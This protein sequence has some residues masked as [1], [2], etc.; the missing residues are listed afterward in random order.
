MTNRVSIII[1]T[2]NCAAYV[3][4]AVRSALEQDLPGSEIIVVDDGSSDRTAELLRSWVESGAIQYVYQENRGLPGARNTGA[5]IA[6]GEYLAFLDADDVFAPGAVRKMRDAM[7][8]SAAGWCLVDF[9]RISGDGST[10][11]PTELP[12]G[13]PFQS[14][15]EHNFVRFGMFFRKSA[16]LAAGMYDEN[17]RMCEDWDL[18]IRMLERRMAFVHIAEPLY[19]YI[20]R[21]GSITTGHVAENLR[22]TE[23][24]FRKHLKRLA[25]GGDKRMRLLYAAHM[26]SMAR[27]YLYLVKL[28][29][30]AARC[31]L[32]SLRYDFSLRRLLHPVGRLLSKAFQRTDN[33]ALKPVS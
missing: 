15:L 17:I 16:F 8:A 13:D 11:Q 19:V 33:E 30:A 32:E 6:S 5:R 21:D 7:D 14:I 20:K 26:W 9:L 25:D 28:P 23:K 4:Q 1:P 3:E 12:Q 31:T 27:K 24:M 10:V 22:Y 29:G 2:Y 18:N